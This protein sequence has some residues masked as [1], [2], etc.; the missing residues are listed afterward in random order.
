MPYRRRVQ[1]RKRKYP[2][3]AINKAYGKYSKLSRTQRKKKLYKNK[4]AR[5]HSGISGA[6]SQGSIRVT[7]REFVSKIFSNVKG[8]ARYSGVNTAGGAAATQVDGG[9]TYGNSV[10]SFRLNPACNANPAGGAA[11]DAWLA[12][13]TPQ[14][15]AGGTH[16][17]SK[18]IG[19][20]GTRTAAGQFIGGQLTCFPWLANI[21]SQYEQ[22]KIHSMHIEYVPTAVPSTGADTNQMG[23]VD[24]FL[25]YNIQS[26]LG[27][28]P[29]NQSDFLNNMYAVSTQ[30]TKPVRMP[31]ALNANL[32]ATKVFYNTP[33]PLPDVG[34]IP[35]GHAPTYGGA[36]ASG[37]SRLY[38]MA[39]LFVCCFGQR[40]DR[41]EMGQLWISYDIE[42]IKPQLG[43]RILTS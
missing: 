38:D 24:F 12:S 41:E 33:F 29:T 36:V 7:H 25:E 21:A 28:P 43:V 40:I 26:A 32:T 37:D 8:A 17:S 22:Y 39:Q 34:A 16:V 4:P 31:L 2:A 11:T 15:P 9:A 10:Q 14:L 27:T 35:N 3:S 5:V 19:L 6:H 30:V 42:L 13:L 20:N 18:P 1:G 23:S